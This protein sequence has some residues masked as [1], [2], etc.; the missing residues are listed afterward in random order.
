[1]FCKHCGA[2]IN[3]NAIICIKCGCQIDRVQQKE[4]LDPNIS[5][6]NGIAVLLLCFF[7]GGLGIHSF[8]VGRTGAGIG[9][10][11]TLGG[12]GIWA[13]IDFIMIIMGTYK[14]AEG[15]QIKI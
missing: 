9:Q 13:L 14:D 1:M 3:N 12:C 15:K 10:L 11:L 7:L 5:D 8:Y 4:Q 6:K 2:E